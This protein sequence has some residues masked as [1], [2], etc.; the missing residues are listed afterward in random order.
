MKSLKNVLAAIAFVFAFGAAYATSTSTVENGYSRQV[1]FQSQP[2]QCVERIQ[3]SE[4]GAVP[5]T[6]INDLGQPI[7]L[8]KLEGGTCSTTPLSRI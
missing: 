7:Q 3:C 1:D 2:T 4:E 6:I 5:C 8:F